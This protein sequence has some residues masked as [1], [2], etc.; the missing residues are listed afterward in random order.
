M[1]TKLRKD[2]MFVT[3]WSVQPLYSAVCKV[4]PISTDSFL[5]PSLRLLRNLYRWPFSPQKLHCAVFILLQSIAKSPEIAHTKKFPFLG[6]F[7][8]SRFT[9]EAPEIL[10][11]QLSCAIMELLQPVTQLCEVWCQ[12]KAFLYN[13]IFIPYWETIADQGNEKVSE[14]ATPASWSLESNT[15]PLIWVAIEPA[16]PPQSPPSSFPTRDLSCKSLKGFAL[17]Q[18]P[19]S[20]TQSCLISMRVVASRFSAKAH[21]TLSRLSLSLMYANSFLYAFISNLFFSSTL[22]PLFNG[23]APLGCSCPQ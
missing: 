9:A 21:L 4:G 6:P 1:G 5:P 14:T 10:C 16:V 15:Y 3:N 20:P 23:A 17:S 13:K 19:S 2:A 22:A 11:T 8:K 7:L 12:V 18:M